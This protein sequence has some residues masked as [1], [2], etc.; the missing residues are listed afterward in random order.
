MHACDLIQLA[1]LTATNS[2]VFFRTCHRFS[3]ASLRQYWTA[4]K[5][6]LDRWSHLL[7]SY[8]QRLEEVPPQARQAVWQLA[9]PVIE[10]VLC[11]EVLTR[12]W[13]AVAVVYDRRRDW[14]EVEPVAR[15]VLS[16][17][18]EARNR[19]LSLMVFGQGVDVDDAGQLNRLRR[20]VERWTD[21][22]LAYLAVDE[23]ISDLAFERRRLHD[24]SEDLRQE[25][26]SGLGRHAASLV[27]PAIR[28]AF[29][30][31]VSPEAPNGD[32]N[33][34]VASGVLACFE[35]ELFDSVGL[36]KSL[37]QVRLTNITRDAEGM[38]EQ[39]LAG[40]RTGRSVVAEPSLSTPSLRRRYGSL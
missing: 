22:L 36:L 7:K 14:R 34:Q 37:W 20:R 8:G 38:L 17:H 23:D 9:R 40:E 12:V 31:D 19:A 35:S 1:A 16:G 15:S 13:T 27:L 3:A 39:L 30:K 21:L 24:F 2:T 11:S 4:S 28:A 10:E 25:Q 29:E 18:L 33:E 5:C 6:R 32:L 26:Q